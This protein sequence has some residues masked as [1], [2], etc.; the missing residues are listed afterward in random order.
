MPELSESVGGL[1]RRPFGIA[2]IAQVADEPG[3]L[4]DRGIGVAGERERGGEPAVRRQ[5]ARLERDGFAQETDG[6]RALA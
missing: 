1:E 4:A 3:V 6:L 5:I 2:G